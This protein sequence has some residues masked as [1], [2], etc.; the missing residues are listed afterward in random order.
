MITGQSTLLGYPQELIL[1]F[2]SETPGTN[3][4]YIS[5]GYY[6]LISKNTSYIKANEKF[7]EHLLNINFDIFP[8]LI[9]INLS[10]AGDWFNPSYIYMQYNKLE[11]YIF[12]LR[13]LEDNKD[14]LDKDGALTPAEECELRLSK[15][16]SISKLKI[17]YINNNI[18]I[19]NL[20]DL[21]SSLNSL[22]DLYLTTEEHFECPYLPNL[23]KLVL[24]QRENNK[25]LYI[26]DNGYGS[27]EDLKDK[28]PKL[29]ELQL[30]FTT[31]N[32]TEYFP[33]ILSL[34]T[35][36]IDNTII[37]VT[38]NLKKL[39][40]LKKVTI[41]NLGEQSVE[42]LMLAETGLG[43]QY[44]Y[45]ENDINTISNLTGLNNLKALEI[46]NCNISE[47][48]LKHFANMT[49]PLKVEIKE[50]EILSF[51]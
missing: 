10:K 21:L 51:K 27:L 1:R 30:C 23:K 7:E 8:N 44:L 43:I 26:D 6:N 13:L 19:N 41:I 46:I 35:L 12:D 15:I 47:K 20:R 37:E 4:F 40:N 3:I 14:L 36:I 39:S 45:E 2:L 28:L 49:N 42:N 32:S 24:R 9:C 31:I 50:M 38:P 29:N 16:H 25:L 11:S 48:V 17:L 33:P 18:G 5:K 22:S 34:K